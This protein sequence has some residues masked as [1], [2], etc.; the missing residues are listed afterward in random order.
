MMREGSRYRSFI[1]T[2]NEV[3]KGEVKDLEKSFMKLLVSVFP[4]DYA[5]VQ[6]LILETGYSKEDILSLIDRTVGRN[7]KTDFLYKG[8]HRQ[9][10]DK[11]YKKK[12]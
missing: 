5:K 8:K 4:A 7:N 9:E 2:R 12:K 10:H 11:L 3:F 1:E 6:E